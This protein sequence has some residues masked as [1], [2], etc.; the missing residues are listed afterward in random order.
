MP[1]WPH[2]I[3]ISASL[4]SSLSFLFL[5]FGVEL[6]IIFLVHFFIDWSLAFTATTPLKGVL[7]K[8]PNFNVQWTVL[9]RCFCCIWQGSLLPCLESFDS[10]F[11]LHYSATRSLISLHI[12]EH[13][14]L[15]FSINFAVILYFSNV[16]IPQGSATNPH[17]F[18]FLQFL[19]QTHFQ[20][21]DC[22]QRW[23][24]TLVVPVVL[25]Q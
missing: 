3:L 5:E 10:R 15:A 25:C 18:H 14:F 16:D 17:F 7:K 6:S 12:S 8:N 9:D 4:C 21:V 2:T 23:W 1:S 19:E 11:P 20:D 24:Y 22:P 13:S